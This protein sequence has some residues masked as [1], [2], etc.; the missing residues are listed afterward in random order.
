MPEQV[1][2]TSRAPLAQRSP[3]RTELRRTTVRDVMTT[4]VVSVSPETGFDEVARLLKSH[5][6]RALPVLDPAGH[7]LGVVS[8]ADLM[9]I[10][11]L[12]DPKHEAPQGRWHHRG[13]AWD[14]PNT[15]GALMTSPVI[16]VVP[17]ASVAEAAR[18]IREH[19]LG[20]LA[21]VETREAGA[22]RL[23]GVLGRSDLL[24]VFLRDDAELRNE[25]V[26]N[27]LTRILLVDTTRLDVQVAEGVVTLLGQLPTRA[28]VR[29]VVEF[30]ERLE[31]VVKVIDYLTY[32]VDERVADA[33]IAPLY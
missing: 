30:I 10:A 6:V 13:G 9:G 27:L 1:T 21:V 22:E 29:L 2:A 14:R 20:W 31:G 15:A 17:T 8:E 23:V 12:G 16:A 32:E 18:V 11:A 5:G 3:S 28:E 4:T 7:V 25:V 19:K 26:D 33:R 24:T